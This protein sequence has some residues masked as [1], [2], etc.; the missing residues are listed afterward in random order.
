LRRIGGRRRIVGRWR[1]AGLRAEQLGEGRGLVVIVA[2]VNDA[3]SE[4]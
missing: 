2:L 4:V 1:P 3:A